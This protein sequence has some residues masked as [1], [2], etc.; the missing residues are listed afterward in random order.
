[1]YSVGFPFQASYEEA[2]S[3]TGATTSP[4]LHV[5]AESG[6]EFNASPVFRRMTST[7]ANN[8]GPLGNYVQFDNVSPAADGSIAISTAWESTNVGNGQQPAVNGI[9]LV[10][11]GAPI[12]P[13]TLSA[14][15][16]GG[17]FSIS[18]PASAAGFVLESSVAVGTGASWAIVTGTPNP[19]A[20]AGS[21]SVSAAT[22]TQ[23][24]R[25]RK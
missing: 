25:L 4:T 19:I 22:G 9:Q 20:G 17:N 6:L 15:L 10:K 8:R 2:F 23:Y 12:V 16:Q 21:T 7:D 18:W 5:K 13:V 11:V 3:V 14:T 1:V 24:Y